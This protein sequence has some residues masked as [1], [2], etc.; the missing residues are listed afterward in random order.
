LVIIPLAACIPRAKRQRRSR[1]KKQKNQSE[2][3][4]FFFSE[5]GYTVDRPYTDGW[6]LFVL[7]LNLCP[8]VAVIV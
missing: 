1:K 3:F 6:T 2:L 8:V 5:L 4:F 7:L